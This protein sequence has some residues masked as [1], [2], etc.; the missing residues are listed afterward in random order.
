MIRVTS[1]LIER[2]VTWAF[3][4]GSVLVGRRVEREAW[5]IAAAMY[6]ADDD[7]AQVAM[8]V[9]TPDDPDLPEEGL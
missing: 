3:P 7:R 8:A 1:R 2:L 5:R 9:L 6:A 4:A